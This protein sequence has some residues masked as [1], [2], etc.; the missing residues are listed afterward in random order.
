MKKV[1]G[2]IC[3]SKQDKV[4]LHQVLICTREP[5]RWQKIQ[6]MSYTIPLAE[7]ISTPFCLT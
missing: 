4:S 7:S 5:D 2:H 6:A 3:R 1:D